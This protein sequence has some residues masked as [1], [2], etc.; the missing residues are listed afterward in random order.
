MAFVT[1]TASGHLHLLE[2]L[3]RYVTGLPHETARAFTAGTA[4]TTGNGTL[5]TL[6]V[7]GTATNQTFTLTCV[8]AGTA[9]VFTV[10]GSVTG[11]ASTAVVGVAYTVSGQVSFTIVTG[12]TAFGA[13]NI[14]TFTVGTGIGTASQWTVMRYTAGTGTTVG[15][16]ILRGPG[17]GTESIFVGVTTVANTVGNY[18]NWKVGGFTGYSGSSTFENQPG[19]SGE[20]ITPVHVPF[21]DSEMKYWF[22]VSGRRIIVIAKVSTVYEMAYLGFIDTYAS[23]GQYPYPL[24]VGGSLS[25][26]QTTPPAVTSANWRWSYT[27]AEHR[28]FWEALATTLGPPTP[29]VN[30][31]NA[32]LRTPGGTWRDM[33][34]GDSSNYF[35]NNITTGNGFRNSATY[36]AWAAS[37]A[38]TA[39]GDGMWPSL[40]KL[41][42]MDACLDGSVLVIPVV[43][44]LGVST[45]DSPDVMGE[46]SGLGKVSSDL[47]A[48]DIIQYGGNDWLVVPNVFRASRQDYCAVRLA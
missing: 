43:L 6:L 23:P 35:P 30:R 38:T 44:L 14:F 9:G 24:F 5:D 18:A 1:G 7:N 19:Y 8:T 33:W 2:L 34:S 27:G 20:S 4:T 48:E 39:P 17:A 46:L 41:D 31:G 40:V 12:T 15:E 28:H 36:A 21:W 11:T 16:L 29:A 26:G 45:G 47:A 10:V 42:A 37:F 22:I 13:G 3:K 25:W 32:R